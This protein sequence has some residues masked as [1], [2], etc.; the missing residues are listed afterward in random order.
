MKMIKKISYISDDGLEF[1]SE[2]ECLNHEQKKKKEKTNQILEE[3]KNLD[4]KIWKKYHPDYNDENEPTL[5]QAPS[6]LGTDVESILTEFPDSEEEVL[7]MI[8]K[9]RYGEEILQK[10]IKMEEINKAVSVRRDFLTALKSVREGS[11]LSGILHYGFSKKDIR[12]LAKIHKS[13]KCRTKIE[14]LLTDCNYH[15]ESGDFHA[16]RYDAYLN[17]PE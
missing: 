7:E 12:E 14:S 8:Q 15:T 1:E 6:W 4:L 16:R 17:I 3:I 2:K 5:E 11:D 9:S 13:G 10:Y